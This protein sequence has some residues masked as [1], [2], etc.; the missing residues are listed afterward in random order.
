MELAEHLDTWAPKEGIMPGVMPGINHPKLIMAMDVDYPPYTY[1]KQAPYDERTDLDEVQ[2]VG[3]DMIN[4]MAKHC[5]FEVLIMQAHW[6]DCWGNN[7]IGH[8]LVEGWYHGCM[9]YTHATGKRNRYLEFTNSWAKPNKPAGLIV[10]LVDG[11]PAISGDDDLNGRIIVDVTG[12]APTADTL[13]FVVNKCTN[14]RYKGFKI[15]QGD[16]LTLDDP[17]KAK[18]ANDR[19]LLAVLEGKADAMWIYGDQAQ[20]YQ[21]SHG[22]EEDGWNCELWSGFGKT[23]AYVQSGMFGWMHNGTTI[24]MSKKGS[25]VAAFLD[26]C[27]ESFRQT[28]SYYEV[29]AKEHHG[30]SQLT[31]CIPNQY[32]YSDPHYHEWD[33]EHMPYMFATSEQ[34]TGCSTGYCTCHG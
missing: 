10:K 13:N 32:F 18:G 1:L 8:G 29:C 12:W 23:F 27:F 4:G 20:N 34:P 7:E 5:G 26:K 24:A 21:C 31:T 3:A 28:Q 33:V 22:T 25:G 17:S 6:S 19:A 30:H 15:V 2:G 16:D 11:K 14:E 9:T